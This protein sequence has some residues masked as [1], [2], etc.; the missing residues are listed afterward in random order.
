MAKHRLEIATPSD[1]GYPAVYAVEVAMTRAARESFSSGAAVYGGA[2]RRAESA[3]SRRTAAQ[4]CLMRLSWSVDGSCSSYW[5]RRCPIDRGERAHE[6][7]PSTAYRFDRSTF[8]RLGQNAAC[9]SHCKAQGVVR[10]D[11]ALPDQCQQFALG[12][13]AVAVPE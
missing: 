4:G 10:H 13:D 7:V 5:G 6:A 8:R 3:P 9:L 11:G 1:G 12:D 2:A